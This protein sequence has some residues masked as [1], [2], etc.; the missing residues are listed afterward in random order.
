[1]TCPAGAITS[2]P[3]GISIIP[4]QSQYEAV[5]DTALAGMVVQ[6]STKTTAPTF[7][8]TNT[9]GGILNEGD[10]TT[11]RFKGVGYPLSRAQ[12]CAQT[13]SGW[14]LPV[15]GNN[16]EDLILIFTNDSDSLTVSN[17]MIIVPIIRGNQA[18]DPAYIKGLADDTLTGTFT[19]KDCIPSGNYFHY[20]SCLNGYT[21]TA[22][23]SN[24]A[25]F[26]SIAGLT[27]SDSLMN[28]IITKSGFGTVFPTI[29]APFMSS[30]RGSK[31]IGVGDNSMEKYITTSLNLFAD[32]SSFSA[33]TDSTDKYKCVPLNPDA[34]VVNGAIQV[35]TDSG[36]LLSKVLAARTDAKTADVAPGAIDPG[37][38]EEIFGI[39]IGVVLGALFIS[40]G[41]YFLYKFLWPSASGPSG[42]S[43]AS[44]AL[45]G[46][47]W[48]IY[49]QRAGILLFAAGVIVLIGYIG[50]VI[51]TAVKK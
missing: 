31:T 4:S 45:S 1:M 18:S 14:I 41:G 29:Q 48:M 10:S 13:H 6:W 11:L 30:F 35:D 24:V 17:I 2:F 37:K 20:A 26:V 50:Y 44:G 16:K 39:I 15:G 51:G 34:D 49:A 47:G 32:P 9:T 25:V 38:L 42:P 19:L 23:A 27:V 43:G 5:K 40:I 33:R 22:K 21:P 28:S 12:I 8:N 7:S 46:S 3:L 36:E